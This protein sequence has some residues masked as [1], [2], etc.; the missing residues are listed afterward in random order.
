MRYKNL[1]GTRILN[2]IHISIVNLHLLQLVSQL[3]KKNKLPS[4]LQIIPVC[5]ILH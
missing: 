3:I 2:D 1:N 4:N 5:E